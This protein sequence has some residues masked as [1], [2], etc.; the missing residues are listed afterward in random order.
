MVFKS[1]YSVLETV[2]LNCLVMS[3]F[4]DLKKTYVGIHFLVFLFFRFRC[5]YWDVHSGSGGHGQKGQGSGCSFQEP[6]LYKVGKCY[7][8]CLGGQMLQAMPISGGQMLQAMPISG[9]QM[10]Q[11]TSHAYIRWTNVTSHAYI[12]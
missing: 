4:E 1:F 8:P 7:K 9:G 6:C 10:L 11:L 3:F 5:Q 2:Y 12:R